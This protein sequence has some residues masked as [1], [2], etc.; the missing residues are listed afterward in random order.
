MKSGVCF[1][2]LEI[3]RENPLAISGFHCSSESTSPFA[4][5][6]TVGAH[7]QG[8]PVKAFLADG[9]EVPNISATVSANRYKILCKESYHNKTLGWSWSHQTT[10]SLSPAAFCVCQRKVDSAEKRG[11]SA[12]KTNIKC[13]HP[14]GQTDFEPKHHEGVTSITPLNIR[15]SIKNVLNKFL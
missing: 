11:N 7:H 9:V 14:S 3:R 5:W 6:S 15:F 8:C 4:C 10:W 12:W 13:C 1:N 2:Q